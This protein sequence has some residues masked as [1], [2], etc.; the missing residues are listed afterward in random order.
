MKINLEYSSPMTKLPA[1]SA[2]PSDTQHPTA[3]KTLKINWK[4]MTHSP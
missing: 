2:N 1:F 3:L 4:T